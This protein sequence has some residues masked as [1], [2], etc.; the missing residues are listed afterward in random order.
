MELMGV[1]NHIGSQVNLL[2]QVHHPNLVQLIGYYTSSEKKNPVQMLVY[3][4]MSG[5]TLMD[6]LYG[7]CH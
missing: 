1:R 5:G 3:E 2:S 6:H 4:Y 7:T